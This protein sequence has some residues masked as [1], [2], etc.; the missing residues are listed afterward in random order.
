LRAQAPPELLVRFGD[1]SVD[2]KPFAICAMFMS[3][4]P[5]YVHELPLLHHLPSGLSITRL[6][7]RRRD[8]GRR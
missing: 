8:C 4:L 3:G 7:G 5:R 6:C 1:F 2:A